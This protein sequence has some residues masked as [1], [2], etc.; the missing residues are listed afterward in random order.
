MAFQYL[1]DGQTDRL[2]DRQTDR[3]TDALI[4]ELC[5]TY[6]VASNQFYRYLV[7]HDHMSSHAVYILLYSHNN[8]IVKLE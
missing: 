6:R 5:F 1:W 3:Q 4:S 7:T 2:A 8:Y